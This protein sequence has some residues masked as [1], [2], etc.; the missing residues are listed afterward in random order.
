MKR[1]ALDKQRTLKEWRFHKKMVHPDGIICVCE[2]QPNRFRKRKAL[3]FPRAYWD[4]W[5]GEAA[6]RKSDRVADFS[7][8]EQLIE[9]NL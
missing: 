6:R 8:Q 1:A 2:E 7:F 3:H 4:W 9:C 5:N